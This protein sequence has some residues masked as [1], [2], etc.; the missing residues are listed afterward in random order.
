MKAGGATVYFVFGVYAR[1]ILGRVIQEAIAG[2]PSC[3][4]CFSGHHTFLLGFPTQVQPGWSL[5]LRGCLERHLLVRTPYQL[6]FAYEFDGRLN[7]LLYGGLGRGAA[8]RRVG[9]SAVSTHPEA[10]GLRPLP[11]GD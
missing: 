6:S 3:D 1:Y 2:R 4:V 9:L 10:S 5:P 11:P 8:K 7:P